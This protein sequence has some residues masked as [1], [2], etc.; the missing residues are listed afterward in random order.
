MLVPQR[1]CVCAGWEL[2]AEL[3]RRP[4]ARGA[5]V[6]GVGAEEGKGVLSSTSSPAW[7][8]AAAPGLHTDK[9]LPEGVLWAQGRLRVFHRYVPWETLLPEKQCLAECATVP[10]ISRSL[11]RCTQ[12][13]CGGGVGT[14]SRKRQQHMDRSVDRVAA[15]FC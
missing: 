13:V 8:T 11:L 6:C 7:T 5:C 12:N 2:R 4:K 3:V 15:C 1:S 9:E 10:V 14:S